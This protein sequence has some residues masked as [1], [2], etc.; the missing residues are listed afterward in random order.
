MGFINKLKDNQ[1]KL[2]F[3][4]GKD[5]KT[6]L[7]PMGIWGPSYILKNADQKNELSESMGTFKLILIFA[8]IL[9]VSLTYHF[10]NYICPHLFELDRFILVWPVLA[11]Y[12][13]VVVFW[14][15]KRLSHLEKQS[16]LK[17][18][19][20]LLE[21]IADHRLTQ[22]NLV[23]S[24]IILPFFIFLTFVADTILQPEDHSH[25]YLLFVI[26]PI[27]IVGLLNR[28]YMIVYKFGRSS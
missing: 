2:L 5:G 3:V 26:A 14:L 13:S 10:G 27:L 25:Y 6:S 28:F 4:E 22:K 15:N 12:I 17:G 24:F 18:A 16:Y 7:H 21:H 20:K 23:W 1:K 11:L 19:T 9:V 8:T